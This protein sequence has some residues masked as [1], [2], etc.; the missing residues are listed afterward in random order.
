M[1]KQVLLVAGALVLSLN[2]SAAWAEDT[3]FWQKMVDAGQQAFDAGKYSK[4]ARNW[5]KVVEMLKQTSQDAAD[6][7]KERIMLAGCL[8]HLGDCHRLRQKW[9]EAGTCYQDSLSAYGKM[10][11]DT[12]EVQAGL[13][14]LSSCY[15]SIGVDTLGE[16]A[17]KM[18]K[19]AGAVGLSSFKTVDGDHYELALADIYSEEVNENRIERVRFNKRICFDFMQTPEGKLNVSKIKG[20]ELKADVCWV[21]PRSTIMYLDEKGE[22]TA[23][24]TVDAMGFM[25]TVTVNPPRKIYDYIVELV[26]Q[27]NTGA[28]VASGSTPPVTTPGVVSDSTTPTESTPAETV[29]PA[30][31]IQP[32]ESSISSDKTIDSEKEIESVSK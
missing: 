7:F 11:P 18:L 22:T 17:S 16:E 30:V 23:E 29:V 19:K 26:K 8:K 9:Q 32:A 5:N 28:V 10:T 25:K 1:N 14:D 3:S 13:S 21:E 24:V 4:A 20:I 2:S 12:P 6:N 27:V 15:K 31:D